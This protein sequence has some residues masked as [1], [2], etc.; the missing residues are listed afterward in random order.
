MRLKGK[1]LRIFLLFI[2]VLFLLSG[3]ILFG[4]SYLLPAESLKVKA[5]L[6]A[7]DGYSE[8]FTIARLEQFYIR[9]RFLSM[10][11][12]IMAGLLYIGKR[13]IQQFIPEVL[14]VSFSSIRKF[15]QHLKDLARKEDKIHLYAFFMILILGIAI[16][17]FFIFE[18]IRYDEAVT[19]YYA[20]RPLF[21]GL[22]F[23]STPNNH[24][25]HTFLV[26]IVYLLFGNRLWILRLPAFFAGLLLIPSSYLVTRLFYNKNAA[27]LTAGL[28][29][30]SSY[31]ILYST[32]ARGYTLVCLFFL[33]ILALGKYIVDNKNTGAW[34]FFVILSALGFYTIPIML[35]PFGIVVTWIF[36]SIVVQNNRPI[37]NLQLKS[38]LITVIL[39]VL[40]TL[41]L[42]LPVF[43]V[44]GFNSVITNPF[45]ASQSWSN[46][47]S[48]FFS[49]LPSVW[50][51]W[52]MYVPVGL[53]L[54]LIIG[55]L[56]SLTFHKRLTSHRVPIILAVIIWLIPHLLIQRVVPFPRVWIF[57]LPLYLLIASSGICYLL[58]QIKSKFHGDKSTIITTIMI[59]ML[60]FWIG[61]KL[62]DSPSIYYTND[63]VTLRDA[64]SITI[65]LKG[66]LRPDVRVLCDGLSKPILAY[67]FDDYDVPTSYLSTDLESSRQLIVVVNKTTCP[68][69]E[70]VLDEY[71]LSKKDLKEPEL[72]KKYKSA[73]IYRIDSEPLFSPATFA[74]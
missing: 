18:P 57:L 51:Y 8:F 7:P 34:L 10:G 12:V 65:F 21:I 30:S 25:F 27:L 58:N 44:S 23:Y 22:S 73:D 43:V 39:T 9:L 54:I 52:N 68:S 35:Y 5:D 40:L 33:L 24:L 14:G 36:L 26:H 56:T 6:L 60:S 64:E 11:L 20:S 46:F 63:R 3:L 70:M 19:T 29:S 17:L 61:L 16:R 13:P 42:Y 59:V 45:V 2:I 74:P 53:Q 32:N 37:R 48:N 66:Y 62:V 31:L 28:V 4:V 38:L 50:K 1:V 55:F 49:P 69:L 41:I 71:T 15:I 67:Y 72:I 47:I